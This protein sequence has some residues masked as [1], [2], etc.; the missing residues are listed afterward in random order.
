MERINNWNEVEAK[1][2]EDFKALPIGAYECIIKEAEVHKNQ[3]TGK[4]SFKVAI[5]IATGEYKEY[6]QKRYD[7]NNS[8]DKKWDNNATRYLAFQGENVSYFKGFI[9]CVENSNVGYTWNWDEATLKGKKIC[10]VFQYEEYEKQ[11]GS[12][13]VKVRLSKFRSMD[14]MQEAK[15][16]LSDSVRLLNGS[17]MSIDDYNEIKEEKNNSNPFNEFNDV[18]EINDSF[19]D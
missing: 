14:K 4:E 19:L 8:S 17:Y 6:F 18:V 12:K 3:E 9:T 10:G 1:G 5:D 15:E 16:N 13:A 2:M 11:D 7:N